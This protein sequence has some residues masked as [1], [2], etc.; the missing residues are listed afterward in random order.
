SQL[1]GLAWNDLGRRQPLKAKILRDLAALDVQ[2]EIA[3]QI[4]AELPEIKSLRDSWRVPLGLLARRIPV[5]DVDVLQHGGIIA[6]VGPTG[7]GK[8]TTVAKLAARFALKHGARHV[9]LISTD[10]YR[11]GAREQLQTYARIL[12]V[13]MHVA[14]DREDLANVIDGLAGRKLILI[15]T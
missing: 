12:G 14:Q 5:S 8:T 4:V 1:A 6:V 9:A 3:R 2:P 11:I 15:D 13:P 10:T 7:V